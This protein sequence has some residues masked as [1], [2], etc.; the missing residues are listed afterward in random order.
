[1]KVVG[2]LIAAAAAFLVTVLVLR[3]GHLPGSMATTA[4]S[5]TMPGATISTS[6]P[7]RPPE[8]DPAKLL[9]SALTYRDVDKVRDILTQHPE[10][11]NQPINKELPLWRACASRSLPIVQ[12]AVEKGANLNVPNAQHQTALWT[13][14]ISDN[15][16]I[17]KYLIDKGAD[18]KALQD[19]GE[20]LLWAAGSKPMAELLISA[21][22]DPKHKNINKDTALHQACRFSIVDVV[23]VL[24]DNGLDIE[25]QGN[26]DMRP[27]HSSASSLTGDSRPVLKLLLDRGANINSH[28]FNGQT[29]FH[30]CVLF[31]R[32]DAAVVLFSDR[33]ANPNLKDKNGAT[34]L[35]MD[36]VT[37]QTDRVKLI[38]LLIR[39]GAVRGNGAPQTLIPKPKDE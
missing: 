3:G 28:G 18:P 17:V 16:D 12:V 35:D 38:N 10:L 15:L 13:A 9:L 26:W 39:H 24:L 2:A 8:T 1:M 22:V 4:P 21:G 6:L 19:D 29:V 34:P 27:I 5:S 23:R 11:V 14:V 32:Y 31:N 37:S 36:K 33:R 20:T 30:E 7:P 25:A